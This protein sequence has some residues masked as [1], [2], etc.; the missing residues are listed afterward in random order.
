MVRKKI[1]KTVEKSKKWSNMVNTA[2]VETSS[3]KVEI[4]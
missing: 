2:L 4:C 3:K 1:K